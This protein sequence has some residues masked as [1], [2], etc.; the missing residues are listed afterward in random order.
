MEHVQFSSCVCLANG[1]N[2]TLGSHKRPKM[3]YAQRDALTILVCWLMDILPVWELPDL[4]HGHP[5]QNSI[6]WILGQ[7]AKYQTISINIYCSRNL[8]WHHL[9]SCVFY[10][11]A[12]SRH[13]N[14]QKSK[15]H[16]YI[17]WYSHIFPIF[18][19]IPPLF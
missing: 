10:V 7:V 2:V 11:N 12:P 18:S 8:V 5:Q 17:P 9:F 4:S 1:S 6:V 15:N 13:E 19:Y 3:I 16:S 14:S